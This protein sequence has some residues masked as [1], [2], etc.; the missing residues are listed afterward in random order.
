VRKSPKV[1][2]RV[3]YVG[4][5]SWAEHLQVIGTVTAVHGP[6]SRTINSPYLPRIILAPPDRKP[7]EAGDPAD[8]PD[9]YRW[10]VMFK[11]DRPIPPGWPYEGET[12][13]ESRVGDLQ[14]LDN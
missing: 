1:G 13:F 12:E 9:E 5:S 2:D 6:V 14:K 11:P 4:V 7:Q 10:F 8:D 3:Q